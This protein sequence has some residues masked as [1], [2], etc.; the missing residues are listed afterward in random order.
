MIRYASLHPWLSL[1]FVYCVQTHHYVL[2]LCYGGDKKPVDTVFAA[3]TWSKPWSPGCPGQFGLC[4]SGAHE[5]W[6]HC[7]AL[8]KNWH[9]TSLHWCLQLGV[10]IAMPPQ[11]LG[12]ECTCPIHGREP[13]QHHP[14]KVTKPSK[15]GQRLLQ[16]HTA[17]FCSNRICCHCFLS[18]RCQSPTTENL[19]HWGAGKASSNWGY[20][21]L[22]TDAW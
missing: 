16:N 18:T 7:S 12:S 14:H 22:Y 3:Y 1:G 9:P 21:R 2:G 4:P 6:P 15:W 13:Y 10:S 11:S 17:F 8:G 20:G 19:M 5:P